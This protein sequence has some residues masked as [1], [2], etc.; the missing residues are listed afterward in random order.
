MK[1]LNFWKWF[2]MLTTLGK[3]GWPERLGMFGGYEV[4]GS[5]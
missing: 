5:P 2:R 3:L 1:D 4:S